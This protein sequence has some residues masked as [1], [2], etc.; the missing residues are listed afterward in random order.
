MGLISKINLLFDSFQPG[1][2]MV[3]GSE[4]VLRKLVVVDYPALVVDK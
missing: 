1:R 2:A 4:E 3:L